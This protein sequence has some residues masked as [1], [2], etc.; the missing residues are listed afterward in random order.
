MSFQI[1]HLIIKKDSD[2]DGT[3]SI[4]LLDEND[5]SLYL[6]NFHIDMNNTMS[7]VVALRASGSPVFNGSAV[8]NY[9]DAIVDSWEEIKECPPGIY[10]I[11]SN[12]I[13][14]IK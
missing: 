11:T 8:D 3:A 10:R 14:Q 4:K 2:T 9:I 7:P 13:Q 1:E 6:N 5:S 12:E